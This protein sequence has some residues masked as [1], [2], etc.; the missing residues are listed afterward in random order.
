MAVTIE[1]AYIQTFESNVRHLAQQGEALLR[2][3]V[4]EKSTNGE[5]HNW[6]R[7]APS[8]AVQKTAKRTATPYTDP[9]WTRRVSSPETWHWADSYEDEDIVQMLIDPQ[10]ALNMNGSMAMKRAIDDIIIT[11]AT[12]AA[13]DGAGAPVA[14]PAGQII[15]DYTTEITIDTV[16]QV[17]QLFQENDI[18]MDI[19]RCL[20][21]SPRQ[22]RSLLRTVEVTSSDYQEI[23]ALAGNGY[24][25][26]FLGY[27]WI[28]SNRLNAPLAD[29]I[30]C[31][32]MTPYAIGLQ[33]NQDIKT[34][35][36]EDPSNSFLWAVYMQFTMGATRV[37]D[38]HLVWLKLADTVA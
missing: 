38:E 21:I 25:P 18:M 22:V 12:G 20:V 36:A 14:F 10:S 19:P 27:S 15:G 8:A 13:V 26:N 23:K 9:A 1:S 6:D 37:E 16:L 3:K 2:N 4:T 11:A 28:V 33:V 35:V 17:N 24:L 5:K 34:K 30:D 32:A 29:Q 7:L 31:F